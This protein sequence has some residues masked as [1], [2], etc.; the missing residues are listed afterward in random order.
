MSHQ[1]IVTSDDRV[2]GERVGSVDGD[3]FAE[4]IPI[5][6]AK[7]RGS[8]VI[9]EILR[10]I[11]DDT[12]G[13]KYII[14]A[15]GGVSGEVDVR[16]YATAAA[17]ADM[18]IDDRIGTHLDVGSERRVRMDNSRG[19]DHCAAQIKHRWSSGEQRKSGGHDLQIAS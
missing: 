16:A 12:A 18:G 9:F 10:G 6:D 2:L 4:N 5:P 15:E 7:A 17:D 19:M 13:M 3:V 14:S 1:E 8:S 11:S